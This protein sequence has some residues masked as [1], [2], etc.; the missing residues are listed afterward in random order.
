MR[1]VLGCALFRHPVHGARGAQS[2]AQRGAASPARSPRSIRVLKTS[3]SPDDKRAPLL[4]PL[5]R[6]C[7]G[8][9]LVY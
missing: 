2:A 8:L 9:E 5:D 6:S 1:Q 7:V 3:P 4:L